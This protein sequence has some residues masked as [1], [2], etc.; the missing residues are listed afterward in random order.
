MPCDFGDWQQ[1]VFAERLGLSPFPVVVLEVSGD[2]DAVPLGSAVVL[3]YSAMQSAE[4][5]NVAA[6][7]RVGKLSG[8]AEGTRLKFRRTTHVQRG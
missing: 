5:D 6:A 2:D 3:E 8:L 4:A 7:I 1:I